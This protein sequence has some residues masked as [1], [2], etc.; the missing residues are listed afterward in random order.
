MDIRMPADAQGLIQRLN[1]AGYEAYAVGGCVRDSLLGLQPKDWDICTSALPQQTLQV[2]GGCHVVETGL[3][4]GT[5]TV[6]LHH[7]PYE[8]T[9]FRVDGS[10]AD[11]R[12]PDSVSFV[13][14]VSEDLARRDFTVNAMAWHPQLGLTDLFGGREDLKN[15]VLRCVGVPAARFEEDA[16]RILRALRFSS[17]YDFMIEP[18]TAAAIHALHPT[19]AHVAGERIHAELAKLL[20]GRAVGRILREYTDV[21]TGI[22]P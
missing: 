16:L 11:H 20:C 6:V 12:H 5:V 22:I 10:Y 15:G 21:I 2:F 9:S 4:H 3:K 13:S 19:L 1:D 8:V 14:D 7:V 17:V 18:E